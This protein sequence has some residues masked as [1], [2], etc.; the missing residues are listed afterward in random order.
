MFDIA[1]NNDTTVARHFNQ[2]PAETPSL[3]SGMMISVVSF[4]K[5]HPDT[6]ES[7]TQRDIEERIWMHQLGS[8]T[9]H[10]LNLMD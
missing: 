2:C 9:P 8:I 6:N 7:R 1:H 3:S 10:G 4:I 5:H